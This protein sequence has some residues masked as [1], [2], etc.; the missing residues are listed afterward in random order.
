MT[1]YEQAML[2]GQ[3]KGMTKEEV[4]ERLDYFL[5]RF[6]IPEYKNKKIK[7]LSKGNQQKIQFIISILHNPKLLI[8]DEPFSGLDPSN[9]ELFK[10][11]IMEMKENGAMIIFSSHRMDHVEY[12]CESL[13]ILVNGNTV[14][15]G[16][17]SDIKKEYR[18][19][20]IIVVGDV[21]KKTLETIK[22]VINVTEDSNEFI[23]KIE[24]DS[25]I[26]DVFNYVKKC[27][28]ITKFDVEEPTLNE[29]FIE[30]VGE[31]YEK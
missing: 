6:E 9:V 4:E 2:Y 30:K 21:S 1:V 12:F 26:D 23:V 17:L 20:N 15:Q 10:S 19:K 25:Y 7:E 5:K 27:K 29:I 22:G 3:L 24:D 14:L 13:V 31:K 18:K 28:N 11:V 16:K 8:L